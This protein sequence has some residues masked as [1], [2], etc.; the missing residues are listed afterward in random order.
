MT[1]QRTDGALV[2]VITPVHGN[3]KMEEAEARLAGFTR[4]VV[5]ILDTFIPKKLTTGWRTSR[6]ERYWKKEK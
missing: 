3:E 4:D 1:R 5:P 6:I 2:R